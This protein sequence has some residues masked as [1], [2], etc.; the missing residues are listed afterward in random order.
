MLPRSKLSK[1]RKHFMCLYLLAEKELF[2]LT[3]P[4]RREDDPW[5]APVSKKTRLAE[6][7]EDI[8]EGSSEHVDEHDQTESAQKMAAMRALIQECESTE[9]IQTALGR[10][11]LPPFH[12]AA[13]HLKDVGGRGYTFEFRHF[14]A[15]LDPEVIEHFVRLCVAL[16]ISA[17]SLGEPGRPSFDEMYDAFSKIKEW[18]NL[19][20]TIGLQHTIS[21]WGKLLSTYPA[22]PGGSNSD[23]SSSE[24][25]GRPSS[26]LP[27]LE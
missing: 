11:M 4:H 7:A 19:L 12:R 16:L 2:S 24:G 26:F 20:K 18:K 17:K 14:Q 5:A 9:D 1:T 21:F 25:D 22:A 13:L 10:N 27:P 8:L 3:A 6:D 23:S 15:S